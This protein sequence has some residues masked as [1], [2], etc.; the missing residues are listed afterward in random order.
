[1][2]FPEHFYIRVQEGQQQGPYNYPQLKRLY[3]RDLIPKEALYWQ[4]GMEEWKSIT[5]LCG[6]PMQERRRRLRIRRLLIAL[7]L[8]CVA[9][10]A[11]YLA[12]IIREGWKETNEHSYSREAAYWKARSYV[13]EELRRSH[14][15]VTFQRF[16][17]KAVELT[18]ESTAT[19]TLTGSVFGPNG[20]STQTAWRVSLRF[21]RVGR[22][23]HLAG[24]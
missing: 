13:R 16:D 2:A 21:N 18:K 10:C 23:W 11:A 24:R 4:E 6:A 1:M 12:P 20:S 17:P 14:S 22:E 7:L 15:I 8:V 9:A 3:D 19:V 5:D